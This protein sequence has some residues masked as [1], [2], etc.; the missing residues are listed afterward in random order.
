M[1][2]DVV[3]IYKKYF[4]YLCTKSIYFVVLLNEEKEGDYDI[5]EG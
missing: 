3:N 1:G 2:R 4:I 5:Y